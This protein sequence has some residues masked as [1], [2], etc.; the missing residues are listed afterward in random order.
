M[1]KS[2]VRATLPSSSSSGI[3]AFCAHPY[4]EPLCPPPTTYSRKISQQEFN[5]DE[6]A[7]LQQHPSYGPKE[8]DLKGYGVS[9]SPKHVSSLEEPLRPSQL[10]SWSYPFPGSSSVSIY[11]NFFQ[12]YFHLQ[13]DL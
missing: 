10:N 6:G 5:S 13:I 4:S 12:I 11:L 2:Q 9:Q 8:R 3:Q 7:I 1:D